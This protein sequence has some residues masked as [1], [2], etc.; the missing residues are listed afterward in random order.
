MAIYKEPGYN[1]IL[2]SLAGVKSTQPGLGREIE[3]TN[4]SVSLMAPYI[5]FNTRR[6]SLLI[7]NLG[8]DLLSVSYDG[9]LVVAVLA[10]HESYQ[11]DQDNPWVGPIYM[12]G[13]PTGTTAAVVEVSVP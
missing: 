7:Q 11:I 8:T 4:P 12:A 1:R 5:P 6:I 13:T 3:V 10:Y 9:S 2:T